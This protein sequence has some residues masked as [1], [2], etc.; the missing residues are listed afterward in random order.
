MVNKL[1]H[2]QEVRF[3]EIDKYDGRSMLGMPEAMG[4]ELRRKTFLLNVRNSTNEYR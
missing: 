3:S 1:I 2:M 4:A